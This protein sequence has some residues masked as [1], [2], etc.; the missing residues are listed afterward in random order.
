VVGGFSKINTYF[1]NKYKPTSIV[2]YADRRWSVGN[3]YESCGFTLVHHSQPNY[4]YFH[5]KNVEVLFS[6]QQFQKHLL[7]N[8][9]PV[10]DENLTE[11]GNMKANGYNRIWDSGNRVYL[12]RNNGNLS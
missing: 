8:K 12:W 9:L 7:K 2:S 4:S 1:K 3:L 5:S 6:R 10:F 11:W